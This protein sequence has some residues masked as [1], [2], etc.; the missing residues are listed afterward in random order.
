MK[1]SQ[2][3]GLRRNAESMGDG[4]VFTTEKREQI[5]AELVAAAKADAR[6]AAR[7]I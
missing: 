2:G 5:R 6:I 4:L 7:H 1:V 3:R